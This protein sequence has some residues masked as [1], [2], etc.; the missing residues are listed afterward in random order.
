[1]RPL[2]EEVTTAQFAIGV[3]VLFAG[4]ALAAWHGARAVRRGRLPLPFLLAA[5]AFVA[6]GATHLVQALW[7]RGY[8]PGV[9]T[10]ALVVL[11][12]GYAL[13]RTLPRAGVVS[14]AGLRRAIIAGAALQVPLALLALA[15]VR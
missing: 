5:G 13:M 3:A 15:A 11:P 7:F 4:F 9:A 6:N 10:A 1:M 2:A 12:Y 14:A 8:T